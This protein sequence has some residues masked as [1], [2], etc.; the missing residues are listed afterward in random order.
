[1]RHTFPYTMPLPIAW[2]P[3][4]LLFHPPASLPTNRTLTRPSSSNLTA[5]LSPH[6][7]LHNASLHF[8][9]LPY[10]AP[11]LSSNC[12]TL[13]LPFHPT[14]LHCPS[15]FIQLPYTAPPL[16]FN[17]LTLPLPFHPTALHC[18]SSSLP[19]LHRS[20]ACLQVCR[21]TRCLHVQE[22]PQHSLV[23]LRC[24]Q[25]LCIVLL[26]HD[27]LHDS[28]DTPEGPLLIKEE[29]GDGRKAVETLAVSHFWVV[30][31]EGY[32]DTPQLVNL[33][34]GTKHTYTQWGRSTLASTTMKTR[35]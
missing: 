12:L 22:G 5:S 7:P 9:Q 31:T 2:L 33:R 30:P 35:K 10:T 20:L 4:P 34:R 3:L 1:M 28:H 27:A 6:Q 15:P 17:C 23:G 11:P 14:A 13:P 24:N 19:L 25:V 26:W 16:S 29:E 8:I 18:P 32:Q 21:N